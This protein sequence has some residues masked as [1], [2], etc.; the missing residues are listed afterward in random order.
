MVRSVND[1]KKKRKQLPKRKTYEQTLSEKMAPVTIACS[2]LRLRIKSAGSG[3][4]CLRIQNYIYVVIS[5]TYTL[6]KLGIDICFALS[7]QLPYSGRPRTETATRLITNTLPRLF[8]CQPA[9]WF[10]VLEAQF[11]CPGALP[12]CHSHSNHSRKLE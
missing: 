1:E 7:L 8:L 11:G 6:F 12:Y 4:A 9:S 10:G 3:R 2:D 5:Y